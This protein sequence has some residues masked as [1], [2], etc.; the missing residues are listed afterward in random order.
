MISGD[1][2]ARTLKVGGDVSSQR[3][4]AELLRVI[5]Q[6]CDEDALEQIEIVEH[7]SY[8]TVSWHTDAGPAQHRAYQEYTI[9]ELQERAREL[10][11]T[12]DPDAPMSR[13]D[14]L[15]TLGQVLDAQGVSLTSIVE[16]ADGYRIRGF[17]GRRYVHQLVTWTGLH[18]ASCRGIALRQGESQRTASP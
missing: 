2:H 8:L 7:E 18:L 5:G 15:R 11:G 10:R 4:Y 12:A 3:A 13:A 14:R 17:C 1:H 9:A 6:Q 16:E